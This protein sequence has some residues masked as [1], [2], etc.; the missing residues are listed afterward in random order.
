MNY[1]FTIKSD[2]VIHSFSYTKHEFIQAICERDQ[3]QR[4]L[5]MVFDNTKMKN[6]IVVHVRL[7]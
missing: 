3:L 1:L 2:E 6:D 5:K 7:C 4:C